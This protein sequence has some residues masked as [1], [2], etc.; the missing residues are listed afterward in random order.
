MVD[1]D[2]R[3]GGYQSIDQLQQSR[4]PMPDTLRSATGGGGR[5]LFYMHPPGFVIPSVRGWLPGVDMKSDGGY[6]I[7]PEG[8]HKSGMSYR[9]I[10]WE[11]QHR[12]RR[13]WRL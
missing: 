3:H 6:V 1:I 10:N 2:P 11:N 5:H 13:T 4:G 12:C 9:R 8:K 7:L